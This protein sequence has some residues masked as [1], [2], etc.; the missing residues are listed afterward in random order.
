[1][2]E[3]KYRI[4]NNRLQYK[5]TNNKI[6]KWLNIPFQNEV[7]TLLNY[8]HYNNNHLKKDRMVIHVIDAGFFWFGFSSDIDK[9]IK[10][11]GKNHCEN[12]IEK[13]EKENKIIISKG[14]HIRYQADI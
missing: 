10:K 13:I 5:Y 14:P 2:I 3:N 1:M 7:E 6:I 9:F 11:C 4:I 8:T 12:N